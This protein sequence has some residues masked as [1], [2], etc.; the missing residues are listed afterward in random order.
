[1][2]KEILQDWRTIYAVLKETGYDTLYQDEITTIVNFI[3]D[4]MKKEVE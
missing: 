2:N 1:M 4:N 3:K